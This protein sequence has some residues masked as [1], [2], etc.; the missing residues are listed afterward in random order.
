MSGLLGSTVLE[1]AI[2]LAFVYLLVS[3]VVTAAN[4]LVASAL[5]WRADHLWVGI[6]NLLNEFD[7]NDGTTGGLAAKVYNHPLIRQLSKPGKKPSYIPSRTFA[8][9]LLDVLSDPARDLKGEIEKLSTV[10]PEDA[11]AKLRK[12]L[13]TI[14]SVGLLASETK[15]SLRTTI[16]ALPD[17]GDKKNLQALID[18]IPSSLQELVDLLPDDDIKKTLRIL[19]EESGRDAEKLKENLE[20][21]FNNA[22]DRVS[23]WYKRKTQAA[24]VVLALTVTIWA[25]VDSI[26]ITRALSNDASLRAAIVVQ[27]S[28]EQ[29]PAAQG[30]A[31]GS[32]AQKLP[33]LTRTDKSRNSSSPLL[34]YNM[35]FVESSFLTIVNR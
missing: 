32:Q 31:P 34:R 8:L 35:K 6:R 20:V 33:G 28:K 27:A 25:N 7:S 12:D 16:N 1:V 9:A 24:Q 15:S 14:S 4:E 22:M 18:R 26:L 3:L 17:S 5:K 2:G 21:W 10:L 11:Q 30:P 13:T 19:L 23:G 29:A